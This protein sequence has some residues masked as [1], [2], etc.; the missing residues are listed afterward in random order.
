M[1][2]L[3]NFADPFFAPVWIRVCLVVVC[4]GWSFF[5]LSN[6]SYIWAAGFFVTGLIAAWR[7][8]VN[9]YSG[10]PED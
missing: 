7:F 8:W 4:I 6:G 10:D 5:E 2:K 1:K 9:D 3:I